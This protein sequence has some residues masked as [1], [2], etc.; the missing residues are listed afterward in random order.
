MHSGVPS[1]GRVW[2]TVRDDLMA[3]G[4]LTAAL[5]AQLLVR[6]VLALDATGLV[7]S[8]TV[9]FPGCKAAELEALVARRL[10]GE[11]VARIRGAQEFYGLD[12]GLNADTLIPRPETE[13]LVDWGIARL[14]GLAAP[15][16]LDL[17]TGT[18]CIALALLANLPEARAV[19]T[20]IAQGALAQAEANGRALGLADR[21]ELR[22]GA[23]YGALAPD[24]RFDLIVSNP[25]YIA[26]EVIETLDPGVRDFDPRLALDGG[27]MGLVPYRVI[28]GEAPAHLRA[29]GALGVEIGHDQPDMVKQMFEL[30]GFGPAMIGRDLAGHA[31]VVHASVA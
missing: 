13:M 27:E 4:N 12:F 3:A 17:G 21:F 9:P 31:R 24:E 6:Q 1:I 5:D 14:K 2:R 10:V 19:G 30:A 20:D 18:G 25:P 15:R 22:A 28:L 29:G 8:D 11:P 26:P 23:W 7:A 16:I